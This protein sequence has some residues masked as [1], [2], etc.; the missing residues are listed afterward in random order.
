MPCSCFMNS[1]ESLAFLRRMSSHSVAIF[2]LL[3]ERR[4]CCLKWSGFVPSVPP[5]RCEVGAPNVRQSH[6][7]D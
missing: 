5:P 1:E 7:E 2:M 3:T 4:F 6:I